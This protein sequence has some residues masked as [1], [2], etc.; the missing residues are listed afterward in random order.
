MALRNLK[1]Y[2]RAISQNRNAA[3]LQQIQLEAQ[4]GRM[5]QTVLQTTH[6]RHILQTVATAVGRHLRIRQG[7]G[8]VR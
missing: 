7:A 4:F 5:G 8:K 2:V 3:V 6:G 1:Y